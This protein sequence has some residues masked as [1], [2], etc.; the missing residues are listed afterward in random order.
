LVND[1]RAKL[2]DILSECVASYEEVFDQHWDDYEAYLTNQAI[3][4]DCAARSY[5]LVDKGYDDARGQ[6]EEAA[7]N[8][9]IR[10]YR[11]GPPAPAVDPASQVDDTVLR[12]RRDI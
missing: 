9:A 12:H 6:G 10:Y 3:V 5:A 7:A 2:N 1:E 11:I 4:A 8:A